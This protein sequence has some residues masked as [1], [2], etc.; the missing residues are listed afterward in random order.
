MRKYPLTFVSICD[1]YPFFVCYCFHEYGLKWISLRQ[2]LY[3]RRYDYDL[4]Q[5]AA[6][7]AVVG[8]ARGMA[9]LRFPTHGTLKRL[10]WDWRRIDGISRFGG[11]D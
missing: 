11:G 5:Q 6:G 1:Y 4:L 10:K 3:D 7:Y 9:G 2:L 8:T